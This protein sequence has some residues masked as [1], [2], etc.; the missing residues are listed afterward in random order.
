[1]LQA[2]GEEARNGAYHSVLKS[3][4]VFHLLGTGRAQEGVDMTLKKNPIMRRERSNH[5]KQSQLKSTYHN[6]EVAGAHS[7][8]SDRVLAV[9]CHRVEAE[10]NAYGWTDLGRSPD[11]DTAAVVAA[12]PTA[13]VALLGQLV[14]FFALLS[15]FRIPCASQLSQSC[16]C[17]VPLFPFRCEVFAHP[18]T[19]FSTFPPTVERLQYFSF[20]DFHL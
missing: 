8:R 20:L 12:A 13:P 18:L 10:H 15:S 2:L 5:L 14:V 11:A 17:P 1:M 16:I 4:A 7:A 19:R 9:A 6:T 3:Q